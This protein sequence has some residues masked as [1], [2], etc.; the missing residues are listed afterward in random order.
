MQ[1]WQWS[2]GGRRTAGGTGLV[3]K[4]V[5][6]GEDK[7]THGTRDALPLRQPPPRQRHVKRVFVDGHRP[8]PRLARCHLHRRWQLSWPELVRTG[9]GGGG[10]GWG[11]YMRVTVAP[12][13]NTGSV[14]CWM[15]IS[16]SN[17]EKSAA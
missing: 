7:G 8:P 1:W 5:A 2:G 3:V 15:A 14:D 11:R 17:P 16:G 12:R 9:D 13:S 10:G 6:A 4:E